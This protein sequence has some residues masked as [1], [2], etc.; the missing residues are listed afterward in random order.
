MLFNTNNNNSSYYYNYLNVLVT[1][2]YIVNLCTTTFNVLQCALVHP[3]EFAI[4]IYEREREE[5]S[6]F[7]LS[8]RIVAPCPFLVRSHGAGDPAVVATH[9][10]FHANLNIILRIMALMLSTYELS[11]LMI[12]HEIR[13]GFFSP[14]VKPVCIRN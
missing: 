9:A 11:T 6:A 3:T 5:S 10:A 7:K 12:E 4:S 2:A 13:S 14:D 8:L 1:Y